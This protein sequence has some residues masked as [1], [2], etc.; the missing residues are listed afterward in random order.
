M[1]ICFSLTGTKKDPPD[2]A[3]LSLKFHIFYL[4][5]HEPF[6][7]HG[8]G[9]KIDKNIPPPELPVNLSFRKPLSK[10]HSRLAFSPALYAILSVTI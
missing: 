5:Y 4:S 8:N 2:T 9:L 6:R 7:S 1:E 10:F 3:S